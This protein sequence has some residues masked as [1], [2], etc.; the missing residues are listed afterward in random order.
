MIWNSPYQQPS[1]HQALQ[2]AGIPSAVFNSSGTRI[3][4]NSMA[5][6]RLTS[7]EVAN[8]RF[9][10]AHQYF[11]DTYRFKRIYQPDRHIMVDRQSYYTLVVDCRL[12]YESMYRPSCRRNIKQA[13]KAG[14]IHERQG[15]PFKPGALELFRNTP[16]HRGDIEFSRFESLVKLLTKVHAADIHIVGTPRG[17]IAAAAVV[18]CSDTIANI[19]FVASDPARLKFRTV[20]LLYHGV[21]RYYSQQ[22]YDYVDLSGFSY[23]KSE[24]LAGI[25]R[26][27]TGFS[28]ITVEFEKVAL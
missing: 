17:R 2:A 7:W 15:Y 8:G 13:L 18:I 16:K 19:R 1:F 21:I 28:K 4:A 3:Y 12:N 22:N 24:K 14:Y 10:G 9:A 5:T 20:N 27:K 23:E 11:T 25:N 26:F 6:P